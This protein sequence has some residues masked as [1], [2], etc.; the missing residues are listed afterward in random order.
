[1][2]HMSPTESNHFL[3]HFQLAHLLSQE[4]NPRL[5]RQSVDHERILNEY[6]IINNMDLQVLQPCKIILV[7][8]NYAIVAY[9]FV[10]IYKHISSQNDLK[11]FSFIFHVMCTIWLF[12]RGLFWISTLTT[13]ENW[14]PGS[15]YFLYWMPVPIEFASFLLFPLYF[16]QVIYPVEW[17]EY[18]D[19]L[20]PSYVFVVAILLSCQA[21][22]IIVDLMYQVRNVCVYCLHFCP[23][24]KFTFSSLFIFRT[25]LRG[26]VG[27]CTH[28]Y[29]TSASK[30]TST[31]SFS[32]RSPPAAS[33]FWPP[34]SRCM[35]SR[36]VTIS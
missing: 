30:W 29:R 6:V 31:T 18:E 4:N 14:T 9:L 22:F 28:I 24:C 20:I 10:L 8:T 26:T 2:A 32:A 1:M 33:A 27:E 23:H 3:T 25:R 5:V 7:I 12:V 21:I 11:S 17:R 19:W 13:D 35:R 34:F 36:F 16:I 15:Y